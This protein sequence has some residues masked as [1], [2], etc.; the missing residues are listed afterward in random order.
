LRN[1]AWSQSLIALIVITSDV[2]RRGILMEYEHKQTS[3]TYLVQ[4][5]ALP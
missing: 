2:R 1:H 4:F 5:V 3:L